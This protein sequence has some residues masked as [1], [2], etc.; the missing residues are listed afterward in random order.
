[1]RGKRY[2]T[3]LIT[4]LLAVFLTAASYFVTTQGRQIYCAPSNPGPLD[5][6]SA[7]HQTERGFP[8]SYYV[9]AVPEN[10]DPQ[11]VFESADIDTGSHFRPVRFAADILIW[12]ALLVV[13]LPAVK[14]R[15]DK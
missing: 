1:M 7:S 11:N 4:L 5:E 12:A 14:R 8:F 15:G 13:F 2:T 9:E 6:L 10:C 3:L